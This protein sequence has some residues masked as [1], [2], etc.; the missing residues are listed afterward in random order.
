MKEKIL[1]MSREELIDYLAENWTLLIHH[2][3]GN[4]VDKSRFADE[5]YNTREKL[6]LAALQVYDQNNSNT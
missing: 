2:S 6:M 3:P 1:K 5:S 4:K